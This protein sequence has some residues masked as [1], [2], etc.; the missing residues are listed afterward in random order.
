MQMLC[1]GKW[2]WRNSP[3]WLEPQEGWPRR[4]KQGLC[5]AG[6]CRSLELILSAVGSHL[7][8]EAV[9]QGKGSDCCAENEL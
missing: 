3:L 4:A 6:S 1:G 7:I 5:C 2:A 9:Q 8:W